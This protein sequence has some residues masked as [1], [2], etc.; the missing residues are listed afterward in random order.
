MEEAGRVSA[1]PLEAS[2]APETAPKPETGT[3]GNIAAIGTDAGETSPTQAAARTKTHPPEVAGADAAND[4]ADVT[5]IAGTGA[6]GEEQS[7]PQPRETAAPGVAKG[8]AAAAAAVLDEGM[9]PTD[10][11]RERGRGAGEGAPESAERNSESRRARLGGAPGGNGIDAC[12][13]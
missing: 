10:A 7:P 6:G 12:A 9:E 13:Q 5:A 2:E 3:S 1:A 11:S 4:S 8:A